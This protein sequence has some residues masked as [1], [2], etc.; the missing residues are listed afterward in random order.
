[1]MSDKTI[2]IFDAVEGDIVSEDIY[3]PDGNI[4]VKKDTVLDYSIISNISGNHI[5]EIKVYDRESEQSFEDSEIEN[6]E[7]E[8]Y[9][10]KIRKSA[11]Y[12][13]FKKTYDENIIDIKDGLNEVVANNA[14][15]DTDMLIEGTQQIL[16]ENKNSLQI[17][18]MLHSMR[19][20]DD[21]T[22]VHCVN[23][24]LIASIIGKWLGYGEND[25]KVLII[26]GILHDIGKLMI[27]N[28]ILT[29]PGKLSSDEFKIMKQHV[30]LGYEKLKNQN[31][32]MRVKE[33][34]LLHHEKC[35]G[36]GYPF[37]LKSKDIPAVAKIIAVAD[38]YDAMTAARVYRGAL[39]P[40]E[41]IKIMYNDAFT[42]FDPAYILP[43]LKNVASSYIHNDVRLSDGRKGKVIL[44]NDNALHLPVVQCGDEFVD[45]SRSHGLSV[46][47]II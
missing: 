45:L 25:I 26:S 3:T 16:S 42:K 5:L 31:I 28:E 23:V 7:N 20:F 27:P 22:Y 9:F 30:N 40:F 43:F 24:A 29:K 33:A 1:M 32:D 14:P 39:C 18:D 4:L 12:K 17:F 13:Q 37:G 11:Q 38:V 19:Q 36:T 46:S 35:D 47:A 6:N 15:I 41:V 44:I 8:K 21:L 10:D 2:F 34:C